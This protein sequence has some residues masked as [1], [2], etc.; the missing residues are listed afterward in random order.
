MPSLYF[1]SLSFGLANNLR[2]TRNLQIQRYCARCLLGFLE[3]EK[4]EEAVS[5]HKALPCPPSASLQQAPFLG[6]PVGCSSLQHPSRSPTLGPPKSWHPLSCLS[7]C[8]VPRHL[9]PLRP[10]SGNKTGL[11]MPWDLQAKAPLRGSCCWI[12]S[13]SWLPAACPVFLLQGLCFMGNPLTQR[14]STTDT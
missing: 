1:I 10:S 11:L 5:Y 9:F 7:L 3:G 8:Q 6:G 14:F 12:P 13:S 4:N 2:S